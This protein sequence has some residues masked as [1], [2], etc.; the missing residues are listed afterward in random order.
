MGRYYCACKTRTCREDTVSSRGWQKLEY[1][2]AGGKK[3]RR[4]IRKKKKKKGKQ[5]ASARTRLVA[6]EKLSFNKSFASDWEK[7]YR[8]TKK[9]EK[10][11]REKNE[12]TTHIN[13]GFLGPVCA[14][15]D[16]KREKKTRGHV[17]RV[18]DARGRVKP[19]MLLGQNVLGERKIIIQKWRS[20]AA[21]NVLEGI[22]R[23]CW[24]KGG[25]NR[26]QPL[27]AD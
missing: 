20:R 10:E 19:V 21:A 24:R 4:R 7:C 15:G 3:K 26:K 5:K 6:I 18:A 2:C 9:K 27:T 25:K 13:E 14:E 22:R 16:F 11:K 1:L 23:L 12:K 8:G 17:A